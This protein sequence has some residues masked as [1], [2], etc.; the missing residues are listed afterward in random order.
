MKLI[1]GTQHDVIHFALFTLKNPHKILGF[2]ALFHFLYRYFLVVTTGSMHFFENSWDLLILIPHLA[3]SFSSFLFPVKKMRNLSN[4]I[5]WRELQLHN[6]VFTSRSCA[7]FAYN[8]YFPGQNMWSRF[9]IVMMFHATSDYVTFYYKEGTTIRDASCDLISS[10]VKPYLDKFYAFSQFSA[11]AS[12]IIP[13]SQTFERA[14]MI[15]F[16]IQLSTFLMTLRLKGII[17]N[18]G[19]HIFYLLSLLMNFH[20]AMVCF[21]PFC[22]E[23][24]Q[25]PSIIYAHSEGVLNEKRCESETPYYTLV[26]SLAFYIWRVSFRKNKYVGWFIIFFIYDLI[27]NKIESI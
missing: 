16:S 11:I 10:S 5:I 3:L 22:V 26:V 25:I 13:T 8:L 27:M 20:T 17:N 23:N 18:D 6:I 14:F 7:I 1:Q 24:A 4:Q 9:L 21:R 19:W 2:S 12:L 15:M